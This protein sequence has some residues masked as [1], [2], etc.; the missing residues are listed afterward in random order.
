MPAIQLPQC[1]SNTISPWQTFSLPILFSAYANGVRVPRRCAT[2]HDDSTSV[3]PTTTTSNVHPDYP[4]SRSFRSRSDNADVCVC[5]CAWNVHCHETRRNMTS[6]I[7]SRGLCPPR[8]FSWL[9]WL[10][11]LSCLRLRTRL[12]PS[13]DLSLFY[14]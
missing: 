12:S 1:T 7:S 4:S 3:W 14:H 5:V 13:P 8:P 2:E 10:S 11:W 9:S 6:L